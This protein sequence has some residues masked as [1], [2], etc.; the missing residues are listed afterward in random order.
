MKGIQ[1][2]VAAVYRKLNVPRGIPVCNTKDDTQHNVQETN[3]KITCNFL[4]RQFN[5]RGI[6]GERVMHF[7]Y[8]V[9]SF[10]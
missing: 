10:L 7:M 9:S 2:L 4:K 8:L 5:S 3:L 1:N 6:K